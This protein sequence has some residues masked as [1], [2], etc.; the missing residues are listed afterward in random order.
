[1]S[2]ERGESDVPL[3]A[4]T[5]QPCLVS[6]VRELSAGSS[7]IG[8]PLCLYDQD[9]NPVALMNSKRSD[10]EAVALAIVDAFNHRNDL[11]AALEFYANEHNWH[12]DGDRELDTC[13]AWRDYGAK[14]R[15]A[16]AKATSENSAK[17]P[18]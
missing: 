14:A 12:D 1:M 2:H 9:D 3:G 16:I 13:I 4:V 10:K 18:R 7:Q 15:A 5:E 8:G 11:L 6:Q 17:T